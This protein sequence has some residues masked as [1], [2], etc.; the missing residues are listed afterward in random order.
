MWFPLALLRAAIHSVNSPAAAAAAA[1]DLRHRHDK[2]LLPSATMGGGRYPRVAS[3]LPSRAAQAMV[4]SASQP[5]RGT[6]ALAKSRGKVKPAKPRGS[7][8]VLP[9]LSAEEWLKQ[10]SR[11]EDS[12]QPHGTPS[13]AKLGLY[14]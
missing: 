14:H 9:G 5:L 7:K 10:L 8:A 2:G 13:E 4:S 3:R 12:L 11:T 1:K 6:I